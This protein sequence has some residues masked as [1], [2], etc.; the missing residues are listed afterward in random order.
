MPKSRSHLTL[1]TRN[2]AG[3]ASA[4]RPRQ[5]YAK[6]FEARRERVLRVAWMLLAER[7]G[8]N[9][10]LK[11]LSQHADVS[12]RTLYNA[13]TD[14]DGVIAQAVARHYRSLFDTIRFDDDGSYKLR[15]ALA[16][17]DKVA[18][19]T[20]R[21]RGWSVTG[22]RMYFSPRT[23]PKVVDSLR[24]MPVMILKGWLRSAQADR[25]RVASFDRSDLERSFANAQWG[26][27]NDWAAGHI[28]GSDLARSMKCNL[29]IFA[30]A[31]GNAAGRA[32]ARKHGTAFE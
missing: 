31:F 30:A 6:T 23:N 16:M 8:E 1:L 4:P 12:L 7:E 9:F 15:E 28:D 19:E 5:P 13:F 24:A 10:S 22:A 29:I 21:V 18:V 27:V 11:E 14:K 25:K 26:V 2:S 17:I 32:E 20:C 3:A